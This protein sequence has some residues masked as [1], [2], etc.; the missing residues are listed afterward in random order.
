MFDKPTAVGE[1]RQSVVARQLKRLGLSLAARNNL[2]LEVDGA[3]NRVDLG[4]YPE[5]HKEDHEPVDGVA[6]WLVGVDQEQVERVVPDRERVERQA[7]RAH[8]DQVPHRAAL[9]PVP[10]A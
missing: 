1:P 4:G 5:E 8:D 3:A 6:L 10:R 2:V 9:P 7:D